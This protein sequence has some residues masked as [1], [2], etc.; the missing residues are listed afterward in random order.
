[1]DAEETEKSEGTFYDVISRI[2]HSI[3]RN[4]KDKLSKNGD[5]NM[6]EITAVYVVHTH[7]GKI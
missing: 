7:V 5:I 6:L 3:I 2:C 1:M 4:K